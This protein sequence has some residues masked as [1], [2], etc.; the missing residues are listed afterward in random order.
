MTKL[1]PGGGIFFPSNFP[2]TNLPLQ[3]LALA[4]LQQ[5]GAW[6]A[7]RAIPAKINKTKKRQTN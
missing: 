1:D 2:G 7:G 6:G 4:M 5:P 3:L